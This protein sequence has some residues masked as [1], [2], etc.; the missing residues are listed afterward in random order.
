M[1]NQQERHYIH[2]DLWEGEETL[3][4]CLRCDAFF[5]EDHFFGESEKCCNH[6]KEYDNA[7]KML[8]KSLKKHRDFGRLINAV[9][10]FSM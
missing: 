9:N 6:W 5:T 4:Y 3:F 10:I 2:G 8:G 1:N 7:I